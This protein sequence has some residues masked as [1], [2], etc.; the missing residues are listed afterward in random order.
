MEMHANLLVEAKKY[1]WSQ[2]IKLTNSS[3][4]SLDRAFLGP[5]FK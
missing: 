2:K 4:Y 5:I 3:L 1:T